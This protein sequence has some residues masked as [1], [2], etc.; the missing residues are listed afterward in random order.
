M[1]RGL[2]CE[3]LLLAPRIDP[4]YYGLNHPLLT[5]GEFDVEYPPIKPSNRFASAYKFVCPVVG[6]GHERLSGFID[7]WHVPDHF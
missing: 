4:D 1:L 6:T 7:Y 3:T 2:D 5:L